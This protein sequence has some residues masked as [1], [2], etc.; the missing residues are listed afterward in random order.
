M[1]RAGEIWRQ[2]VFFF[3][4]SQMDRDLA[5]EMRDHLQRK[6]EKNIAAGMTREEAL[7]LARR[8]LGNP[9]LQQ[10][11]SRA[12]WGFSLLDSLLQDLR[13]SFR[14]LRKSLGFS[15]VA[16]LTLALGIGA[17]TAIFSIANTVLLRP[18]PFKDSARILHV[19]TDDP[20]FPNFHVGVSVPDFEEIK[21]Q[22]HSFETMVIYWRVQWNLIGA[23]EPEQLTG[24]AVTPG[25]L[26]LFGIQPQLGR[27]FQPED[28]QTRKG[29]VVLLSHGIWQRRFGGEPAV[30]G[31]QITLDHDSYTVVGVLPKDFDF[32]YTILVPLTFDSERL[33]ARYA[34]FFFVYAKLRQGIR[35]PAAQAE[36]NSIS[37]RLSSQYPAEDSGMRLTAI[38]LQ[39]ETTQPARTG[40]MVLLGAVGF[41]LLIACA[42][43]GNLLLARGMRRQRE[44]AVRAALGASRG[45]VFRQLLVE[46]LLLAFLGGTAGLVLAGLGIEGFKAFAPQAT[47]RLEELRLE[48]AIA[49]IALVISSLAGV[50]CGLAPALHTSR[51]EL[52]SALKDRIGASGPSGG[53][54]SWLRG[55]LVVSEV[56]LALVLMTGSAL[57][58]Q[59]LVRILKVDPGFRTDH[60]LTAE[61][62]LPKARYASDESRQLFV[63][64]LIDGLRARSDLR[65]SALSD[66]STL[67]HM[68]A[69]HT[70]D[71]KTLGINEKQTTFLT[72][73]VDPGYFETLGIPLLS[74]RTFTD[75]DL[76]AATRVVVINHSLAR[77][78]F[79]GNTPLGKT[80]QLGDKP[81][82]QRQIVGVVADIHDV[83][84]KEQPRPQFYLP[85]L[86]GFSRQSLHL[87]IRTRSGD[88]VQLASALQQSVW[89]I[90]K[91]L[92][93]NHVDSMAAIISRSVA[94]PR[95][96]TWL[97]SAFAMAG[98]SLTV[99]GIYGVISYSVG[100]RTREIG[101][102]VALGAHPASVL[103]LILGQGLRLAL[104]GALAGLVGA[105]ALTRLIASELYGVKPAD[106]ATLA[107]TVLLMFAI[108][109]LA[110]YIPAR[111]ATRVDPVM[112]LRQE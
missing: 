88:P 26:G 75:R 33:R 22:A 90:D 70:F 57:M 63:Q 82:D 94:E 18:L 60:L 61:L 31:R 16:I 67:E 74:G 103:R 108:A 80:L 106:P 112:A 7:Y 56:A 53:G 99:I 87:Y 44:I 65:R 38:G 11:Q 78:Y 91:D 10:E 93:V 39:E 21:S 17:T 40:L 66:F 35:L 102:R 28:E 42:N 27:D 36:L 83:G 47:P 50:V 89:A 73:C 25:F 14:G 4:R 24:A 104:L 95:F 37:A 8:Q 5:E 86:Q 54:R 48:P 59:S 30:V 84:L 15:G 13:Y 51:S 19:W 76:A 55:L 62:N 34:R 12:A 9:T 111:R 77:H 79:P 6:I 1:T 98:L 23:G 71:P 100:Q 92:P 32:P 72:K 46:S 69:V 52:V 81:E 41:L 45:R 64:R 96:R 85:L 58:V 43:V 29:K 105:L 49:W 2:I 3:R 110:A 20:K 68:V 107:G 97:L 109:S 101:I